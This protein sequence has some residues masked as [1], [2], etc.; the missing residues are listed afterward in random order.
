MGKK[1]TKTR[2]RRLLKPV[3]SATLRELANTF[4]RMG[5]DANHVRRTHIDDA[6]IR[7]PWAA[8]A[9]AY[10]NCLRHIQAHLPNYLITRKEFLLC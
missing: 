2:T 6:K 10:Y 8:A 1:L 4:R 7:E 9:N 3:G 5:D